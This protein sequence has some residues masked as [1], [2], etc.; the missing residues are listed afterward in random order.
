[1]HFDFISFHSHTGSP[2]FN[3]REREKK[4]QFFDIFSAVLYIQ[5][6]NDALCQILVIF[7]PKNRRKSQAT[8][9]S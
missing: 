6:T 9:V 3:Q 1:M 7:T 4:T 5:L 8:F 2:S